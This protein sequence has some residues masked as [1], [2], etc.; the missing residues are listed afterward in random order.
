VTGTLL[1]RTDLTRSQRAAMLAL[2]QEHFAGVTENCSTATSPRR[3]GDPAGDD[4]GQLRG[5]STQL[6]SAM[7][8][9]GAPVRVVF[10]GDTIVDRGAW[11][12][13]ALA[14]TWLEAVRTW[15][16]DVPLYWLLITSGFRT[17]RFLPV[18]WKE[19]W[20]R[21]DSPALP[22]ILIAMASERF[23][24]RYDPAAGIV[25]LA[26][27]QCCATA[28]RK[29]RRAGSAIHTCSSFARV[30]PGHA[31]GDELACLCPL[32]RRT[33]PGRL[34]TGGIVNPLIGNS[35]WFAWC[36]PEAL[37][38]RRATRRVAETQRRVLQ[39]I[40][41]RSRS[42]QNSGA[43]RSSGARAVV[44]RTA[45]NRG[46][47]TAARADQWYDCGHE[48]DSVH[49]RSTAEFERGIAPWIV[50]LFQHNLGML[51]GRSYWAL[52]P[53]GQTGT[54]FEDDTEYAGRARRLVASTLAVPATVRH[55]AS[56]EEWRRVTLR[57]LVE[58]RDLTFISVWNPTFLDVAGRAVASRRSARIVAESSRDQLLG[59]RSSNPA[60]RGTGRLFRRR[61]FRQKD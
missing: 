38:F 34:Q 20:P 3:L 1:P 28:W 61:G 11:G 45:G 24:R 60:G 29:S 8:V 7:Q 56:I 52:S 6:L 13:N 19:F 43:S 32:T 46:S 12:S 10:S 59:R 40:L 33:R 14:R 49:G 9:N 15:Q 36:L 58:C 55:I 27:P 16:S 25:R 44:G 39:E 17:Y 30:N 5:F 48:M 35:L 50:D 57:H 2:M 31:R 42:T 41:K 22:A 4:R 54:E 53:V 37:A 21:H 51:G 18:F 47:R 23:G 26:A